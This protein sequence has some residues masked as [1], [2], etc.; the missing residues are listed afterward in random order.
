MMLVANKAGASSNDRLKATVQQHQSETTWQD[1][2]L[3]LWIQW[4]WWRRWR[5]C[6]L[7]DRRK[8]T[9]FGA[10]LRE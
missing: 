2:G 5:N 3:T 4:V 8:L 1:Q 9:V 7:R 6:G 10:Q